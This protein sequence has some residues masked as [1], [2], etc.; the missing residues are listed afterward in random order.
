LALL[1]RTFEEAA[2]RQR[3]KYRP[4]FDRFNP[5]DDINVIIDAQKEAQRWLLEDEVQFPLVCELAG[6]DGEVVR[7]EA[8]RRWAAKTLRDSD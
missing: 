7:A 6:L 3:I 1:A 5:D 8:R 4:S 2:G